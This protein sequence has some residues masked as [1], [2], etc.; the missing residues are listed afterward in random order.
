M[1]W[2]EKKEAYEKVYKSGRQAIDLY[3]Y[4]PEKIIERVTNAFSDDEGYW[5]WLDC[6]II[7]EY[8]ITDLKEAIKTIRKEK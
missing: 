8:N 1:T 7:H 4:I 3:K 6:G 5:I 2:E